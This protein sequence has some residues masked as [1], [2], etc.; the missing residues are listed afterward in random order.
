MY[1]IFDAETME[2]KV[3]GIPCLLCGSLCNFF[4]YTE[5]HR[6][7]Q[8]YTELHESELFHPQNHPNIF[9]GC[10]INKPKQPDVVGSGA[11]DP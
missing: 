3:S 2:L 6:E 11:V 10:P 8:S 4:C 5:L 1:L 7:P 9:Y